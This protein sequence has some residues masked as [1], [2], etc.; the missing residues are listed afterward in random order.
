MENCIKT[1]SENFQLALHLMLLSVMTVAILAAPSLVY[2]ADMGSV[3]CAAANIVIGEV[4]AG[5]ATIGVCMFGTLACFGKVSWPMGLAVGA[6][7]SGFFGAATY[8]GSAA[9]AATHTAVA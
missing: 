5:I 8:A 2:A 9:D 1:K 7:I 3:M 6:G 4:G